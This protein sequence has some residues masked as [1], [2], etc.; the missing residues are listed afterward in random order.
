[1]HMQPSARH[2]HGWLFFTT[3]EKRKEGPVAVWKWRRY[4]G[5]TEPAESA[6]A[7]PSLLQCEADAVRYGYERRQSN[8]RHDV[9]MERRGRR[10]R[11]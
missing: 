10:D 6:A 3:D 11:A 5:A 4:D 7:F 1:M 2:E 9:P 8:A